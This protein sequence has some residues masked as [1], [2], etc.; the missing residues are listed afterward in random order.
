MAPRINHC[1][2]YNSRRHIKT[3]IKINESCGRSP[4]AWSRKDRLHRVR[5]LGKKLN[6]P[7]L[8]YKFLGNV[9]SLEA[10]ESH[11]EES[12]V[13]KEFKHHRGAKKL[14]KHHRRLHSNT[15][16]VPTKGNQYLKSLVTCA[17]GGEKNSTICTIPSTPAST[18]SGIGTGKK[19]SIQTIKDYIKAGITEGKQ[20][21]W[22]KVGK[23]VQSTQFSNNSNGEPGPYRKKTCEE[24]HVQGAILRRGHRLPHPHRPERTGVA[25]LIGPGQFQC[26]KRW[27]G[28][29]HPAKT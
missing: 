28:T 14:K 2:R 21:N 29:G 13:P 10:A 15:S 7:K 17:R 23:T 27:R 22:K 12:T 16:H 18:T 4:A 6:I 5:T 26:A 19:F 8:V 24:V 1:D 25:C 9:A 3:I 11:E 20:R